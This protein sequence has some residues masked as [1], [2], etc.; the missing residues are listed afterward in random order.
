MHHGPQT[1]F[2]VFPSV[3]S[4]RSFNMRQYISLVHSFI[5]VWQ[6]SINAMHGHIFLL[7]IFSGV[8]RV[9]Q[10]NETTSKCVI[11]CRT[12]AIKEIKYRSFSS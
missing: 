1:L 2:H 3:S 7:L 10:S 12:S 9:V 8:I 4:F 11:A 6:I 5:S